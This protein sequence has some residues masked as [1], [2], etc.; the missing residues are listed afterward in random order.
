MVNGEKSSQFDFRS[1]LV[2]SLLK[3]SSEKSNEE[4]INES[5]VSITNTNLG[6]PSK[7]ALPTAIRQDEIGHLIIRKDVRR[8]CRNCKSQTIYF[9]KKCNVFLHPDCFQEFHEK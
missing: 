6:R 2:L 9:C 5:A 4:T 1:K 3:S 8:R 7:N